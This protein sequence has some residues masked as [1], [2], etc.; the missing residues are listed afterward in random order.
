MVIDPDHNT[1]V[2][3]VSSLE[4][5]QGP[6]QVRCSSGR[7]CMVSFLLPPSTATLPSWLPFHPALPQLSPEHQGSWDTVK[8]Y[9]SGGQ[10]HRRAEEDLHEQPRNSGKSICHHTC[11]S[12][13]QH[14]SQETKCPHGTAPLHPTR[15]NTSKMPSGSWYCQCAAICQVMLH[16]S[17]TPLAKATWHCP[18]FSREASKSAWPNV[19]ANATVCVNIANGSTNV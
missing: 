5:Q 9:T 12:R 2:P 3:P 17:G 1:H 16:R 7:T 13:Q 4:R 15:G 6:T 14:S 11:I 10:I 19:D 8:G 18:V